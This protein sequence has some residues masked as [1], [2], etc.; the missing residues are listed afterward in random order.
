MVSTGF[1]RLSETCAPRLKEEVNDGEDNLVL[2]R[3][4]E[5]PGCHFLS[6]ERAKEGD[7][8]TRPLRYTQNLGHSSWVPAGTDCSLYL[9]PL[10][11]QEESTVPG[12]DWDIQG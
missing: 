1:T 4:L 5:D 9:R 7:R 8:E 11:S 6:F 2:T 3:L 12:L 10:V